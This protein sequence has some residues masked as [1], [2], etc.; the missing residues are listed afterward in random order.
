LTGF[1]GADTTE[2]ARLG[3]RLDQA[4][5]ELDRIRGEVSASLL[6]T[7]WDGGDAADFHDLWNRTLAGRLHNAIEATRAA[8]KTIRDN[9][10]EQDVTSH[11]NGGSSAAQ[12][13]LSA[14]ALRDLREALDLTIEGIKLPFEL[15][16]FG[17]KAAMLFELLSKEDLI[18]ER[19]IGMGDGV[20][21]AIDGGRFVA[22]LLTDP[23][24]FGTIDSGV[25]VALDIAAIALGFTPAG[26]AVAG[27]AIVWGLLPQGVKEDIVHGVE[28]AAVDVAKASYDVAKW[29]V[30]TTVHAAEAIVHADVAIAKAEINVV[31]HVG[32]AAVHTVEAVGGAMSGGV[33]AVK[34]FLHW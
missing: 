14:D 24:G 1:I 22:S 15:T 27:V 18:A 31:K 9:A 33:N 11:D 6:H 28:T 21:L 10:H 13:G 16:A 2:L 17:F 34:N 23:G 30:T 5:N 26:V 12:P 20:T 19:F 8:A 32:G 29:E 4:A 7:H 25:S 3:I